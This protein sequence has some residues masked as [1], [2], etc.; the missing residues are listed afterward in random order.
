MGRQFFRVSLLAVVLGMASGNTLA[1]DRHVYVNGARMNPVE[2]AFLDAAHGEYIPNGRYWL[3]VYT[4]Q[5]GYEGGPPEGYLGGG[6]GG[7][8]MDSCAGQ[9]FAHDCRMARG[10]E[11]SPEL[12]SPIP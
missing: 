4:G 1:Y 12:C 8:G 6:S 2:L 3:N 9:P 7:G 10:C 5:W 11:Q